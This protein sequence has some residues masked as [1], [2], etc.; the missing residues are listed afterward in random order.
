[1]TLAVHTLRKKENPRKECYEWAFF[2]VV[3]RLMSRA[4]GIALLNR[5][6]MQPALIEL[7][8]KMTNLPTAQHA[9]SMLEL[10]PEFGFVAPIYT[11]YLNSSNPA[12]SE[13][14]LESLQAKRHRTPNFHVAGF[15]QILVPY[16]KATAAKGQSD[17]LT[18]ALRAVYEDIKSDP[19]C[20]DFAANDVQLHKV[21]CTHGPIGY[22]L[23]LASPAAVPVC[24]VDGLIQW[25]F[26][27]GNRTYTKVF[28]AAVTASFEDTI[29]ATAKNQPAIISTNGVAFVPPHLFGELAKHEAGLSKL[30]PHI[31][32][33]VE[34]LHSK[35]THSQ[36]DAMYALAHF[37]SSPLADSIVEKYDL[38]AQ[39]LDAAMQSSSFVL[40]GALLTAFSLVH[41]SHYFVTF[42]RAHNWEV[43][44]FGRSFAVVPSDP[45]AFV[46][47]SGH[48]KKVTAPHLPVPKGAKEICRY[49]VALISP[50]TSS[51]AKSYCE[52]HKEELLVPEVA[53]YAA[54]ILGGYCFADEVR[55]YLWHRT[56]NVSLMGRGAFVEGDERDKAEARARLFVITKRGAN[57]P[58]GARTFDVPTYPRAQLAAQCV[59]ED[60]A[61][62]FVSDDDLVS[63]AGVTRDEFYQQSEERMAEVRRRLITS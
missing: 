24:D 18:H 13:S 3:A 2:T 12:I 62:W 20:L 54:R 55:R 56:E 50:L 51:S 29:A 17:R 36:R 34:E 19:R 7:A 14:A 49:L 59:P 43:F 47:R 35:S 26:D 40:R 1:M 22:S 28:D 60:C 6:G 31:P 46:Q 41:Q 16:V 10:F 63:A 23:L 39:M 32:K 30:T 25:W 38:A 45:I 33:L 53:L 61:E 11:A 8:D 15:R 57:E 9:M 44:R 5:W 52:A 37:A 4:D 58:E 27:T 48:S 21:L 42:L